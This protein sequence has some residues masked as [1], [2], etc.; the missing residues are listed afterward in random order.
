MRER[1]AAQRAARVCHVV[2]FDERLVRGGDL[3]VEFGEIDAAADAET[4]ALQVRL[5]QALQLEIL[6]IVLIAIAVSACGC[7]ICGFV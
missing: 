4:G 5:L 1:L 3:E 7:M 6:L 2:P